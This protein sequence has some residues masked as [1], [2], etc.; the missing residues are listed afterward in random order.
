MEGFNLV[1]ISPE[2]KEFLAKAITS[3]DYVLYDPETKMK[4]H[5]SRWILVRKMGFKASK[6]NRKPNSRD[7]RFIKIPRRFKHGKPAN[8]L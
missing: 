7:S 2:G 1:F 8:T 5:L 4:Q 6:A 3:Q